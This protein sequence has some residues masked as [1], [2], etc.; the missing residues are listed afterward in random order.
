MELYDLN[1]ELLT[2]TLFQE[3]QA[4]SEAFFSEDGTGAPG[5]QMVIWGTNVVVQHCKEKFRR[6]VETFVEQDIE[7]DEAFD[8]M[9]IEKPIYMQR[10][11]EVII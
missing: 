8:A 4:V 3:G 5:P 7:Q 11:E 6:F 9:D 2:M 1:I 10:L